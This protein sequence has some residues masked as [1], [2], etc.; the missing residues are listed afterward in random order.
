MKWY[1]FLD[2]ENSNTVNLLLDHNTTA[3]VSFSSSL[4]QVSSD[5]STWNS[6]VKNTARIIKEDEIAKITGNT[7]W[8]KS[9]NDYYLHNNSATEYKGAA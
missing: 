7:T 4:A 1:A 8:S 2:S 6:E 5:A 9:S 3:M